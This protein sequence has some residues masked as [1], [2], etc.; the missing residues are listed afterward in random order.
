MK[1]KRIEKL[2]KTFD[3]ETLDTKKQAKVVKNIPE[4]Y[5]GRLDDVINYYQDSI[6]ENIDVISSGFTCI[7]KAIDGFLPGEIIVVGSRPSHGKTSLLLSMA[8]NISIKAEKQIPSLFISLESSLGAISK[9]LFLMLDEKQDIKNAPLYLSSLGNTLDLISQH[10]IRY[11]EN[12]KVKL[13]YIDYIQLLQISTNNQR[14]W[15]LTTAL[16]EF[17]RLAK[18]YKITIVISSQLNRGLE[19]RSGYQKQ[20]QLSDLRDSG[21]LEQESDKVIFINRLECLGITEDE[22]GNSTKG[23]ANI[24]IAKNRNGRVAELSLRFNSDTA[25]FECWPSVVEDNYG[26]N[27]DLVF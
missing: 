7:D 27:T 22:D 4:I 15:D 9:R 6:H 17:K 25:E 26:L 18:E 8:R 11:A 20:A 3:L 12:K 13:V 1:D 14:N 24:I 21:S 23:S 2:S 19:L 16:R 10:I 5:E